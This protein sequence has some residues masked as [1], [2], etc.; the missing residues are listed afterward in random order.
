MPGCRLPGP[1][2]LI[3][4][5]TEGFEREAGLGPSDL[6]EDMQ[7]GGGLTLQTRASYATHGPVCAYEQHGWAENLYRVRDVALAWERAKGQYVAAAIVRR[8]GDD[9][10]EILQGV[11]PGLLLAFGAF[12]LSTGVGAAI[13]GAVGA[14]GFGAGAAPGAVAGA[15]LGAKVA[16]WVLNAL[17]LAFLVKY[18]GERVSEV[19]NRLSDG[20]RKAWEA[21]GEKGAIDSAAVDMAEAV[22]ILFSLILQALIAYV[23]KAG[24]AKATQRL[25]KTAFGKRLANFLRKNKRV[26]DE[27]LVQKWLDKL[28]TPKKPPLVRERVLQAV[29]YMQKHFPDKSD[30]QLLGYLKAIDFSKPVKV[31]DIA[32][33]DVLIQFYHPKFGLGNFFT[34]KRGAAPVGRLGVFQGPRTF[35]LWRPKQRLK[36]LES[37]AS[38]VRDF[39]TATKKIKKKIQVKDPATG[40]PTG[41]TK[42]VE[43]FVSEFVDG[44][45]KQFMLPA[46]IRIKVFKD[47]N[48]YIDGAALLEPVVSSP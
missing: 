35:T 22:A 27:I 18:V 34:P 23:A 4:E 9:F 42:E 15:L 24:M 45:G 19:G 44:G 43:V 32:P 11:L 26:Q 38:G 46:R 28:G 30:R 17:G 20:I 39:W 16:F 31:V 2:C 29:K 14:L 21:C 48:E 10:Y 25:S 37:N 7:T 36:A 6:L 1:E 12:L 13:G 3:D 33:T 40:K 47:S 41:E 8:T 5:T